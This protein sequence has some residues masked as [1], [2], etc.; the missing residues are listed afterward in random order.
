MNNSKTIP[1]MIIEDTGK[2]HYNIYGDQ[3]TISIFVRGI[4]HTTVLSVGML[5]K[6]LDLLSESGGFEWTIS[7]NT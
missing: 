1:T 7:Q 6:S 3:I 4:P 2:Q 5:K